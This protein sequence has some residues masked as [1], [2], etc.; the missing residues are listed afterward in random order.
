[1]ALRL[2]ALRGRTVAEMREK[3]GHR[4]GRETAEKTVA[5]LQFE[6]LLNDAEFARQWRDSRERK[7][8]RS[9]RMIEQELKQRGVGQEAIS[10]ALEGFDS[11]AAAYRAASRYAARQDAGNRAAFDRRVG[12][13]LS[14][15]GFEPEVVRQ[16]LDQL[17]AELNVFGHQ[18]REFEYAEE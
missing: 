13:F 15:R 7:K 12:A 3:L 2:L 14:R 9:P 8:P 5:R 17:R 1:M 18:E 10:D 4:F 6:G 16:T 11:L